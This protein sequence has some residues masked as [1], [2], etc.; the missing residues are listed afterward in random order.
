VSLELSYQLLVVEVPHCNVTITAA[1]ETCLREE[2]EGKQA[3]KERGK[4]TIHTHASMMAR[5][6]L[7]CQRAF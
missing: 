6:L 1:A 3:E 7:T 2:G 5:F 4:E